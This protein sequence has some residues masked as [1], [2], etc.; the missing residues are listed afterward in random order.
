MKLS[1]VFNNGLHNVFA[2]QLPTDF[3][4]IM[5]TY[6]TYRKQD[7]DSFG[8]MRNDFTTF[9]SFTPLNII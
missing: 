2:A 8:I 3:D 4:R 5:E 1:V 6:P 7:E 9:N